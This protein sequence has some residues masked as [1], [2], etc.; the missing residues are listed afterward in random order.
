MEEEMTPR[1]ILDIDNLE[2]FDWPLRDWSTIF[3]EEDDYV[4]SRVD[5]YR[6]LQKHLMRTHY[7]IVGNDDP[8]DPDPYARYYVFYCLNK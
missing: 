4:L 1:P 3:G 7:Y 6:I 2:A 8:K 5:A